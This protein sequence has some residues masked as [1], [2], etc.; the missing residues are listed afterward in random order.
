MK[1]CSRTKAGA[2]ENQ[3]LAKSHQLARVSKLAHHNL[4]A[5][6][7][8]IAL[9]SVQVNRRLD[10][11]RMAAGRVRNLKRILISRQLLRFGIQRI[12]LTIRARR[13]S[14]PTCAI[15]REPIHGK[16]ANT[17]RLARERLVAAKSES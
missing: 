10:Q 14:R 5:C 11:H 1:E 2:V 17:V 8:E 16:P 3:I 9:Q 7:E 12:D 6:C 13:G 15:A 4:A